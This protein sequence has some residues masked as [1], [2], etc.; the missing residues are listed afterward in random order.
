MQGDVNVTRKTP[1]AITHG[2]DHARQ[3]DYLMGLTVLADFYEHDSSAEAHPEGLSWYALCLA[4][5]SRSFEPAVRMCNEAIERDPDRPVHHINAAMV[6]LLKDDRKAAIEILE[7][8]LTVHPDD[9]ELR[10]FRDQLGIRSKP[11][12]PFLGRNHAV[13]VALGHVM[14]AAKRRKRAKKK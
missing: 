6:Q 12:L 7:R 3:G 13:N 5:V 2:I 9:V 4:S 8:G 11:P 14:H 1:P 10:R